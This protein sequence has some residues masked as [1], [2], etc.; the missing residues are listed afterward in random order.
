MH[1]AEAKNHTILSNKIV[2]ID[3]SDSWISLT[4]YKYEELMAFINKVVKLL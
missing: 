1:K 3:N 4:Y 2:S